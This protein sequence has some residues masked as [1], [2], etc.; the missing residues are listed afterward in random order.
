MGDETTDGIVVPAA[1]RPPGYVLAEGAARVARYGLLAAMFVAGAELGALITLHSALGSGVGL[2]DA[3]DRVDNLAWAAG[4]VGLVVAVAVI[5]WLRRMYRNLSPLG[6]TELRFAPGWAVGAWFVPIL[7]WIRPKQIVDDIWRATE[8]EAPHPIGG[9]WRWKPVPQWVH[10]W[11]ALSVA[12]S[13]LGI[14][15]GLGGRTSRTAVGALMLTSAASLLVSPLLFLVIGRT[16]DRQDQR[17]A[18][19]AGDESMAR[20]AFASEVRPLAGAALAAVVM[21]GF[22][23]VSWS[24]G[25]S[26]VVAVDGGLRYEEFG[27][28]FVYP[29]GFFLQ[30]QNP[31]G[32]GDPTELFGSA[33]AE[34]AD[35]REGFGITWV[36][37]GGFVLTDE[38]LLSAING[39]IGDLIGA[40]AGG[41]QR[42]VAFE[43]VLAGGVSQVEHFS[44]TLDG[45]LIYATAAAA[46]CAGSERLVVIMV[47]V[48]GDHA[49][50]TELYESVSATVSC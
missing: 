3:L 19:V 11:W 36:T 1:T 6:V 23:L 32:E 15:G 46:N 27:V 5:V 7:N 28:G 44:F 20:R 48:L 10:L 40:A 22:G 29:E 12:T 18:R 2:G 50:R 43:S 47:L 38:E 24:G 14:V 30:T 33:G 17:A 34:S 8:L 42:G 25:D 13:L 16:T 45:E 9:T 26:S 41:A 49:R 4:A 35:G 31:F 21:L 37:T 39:G